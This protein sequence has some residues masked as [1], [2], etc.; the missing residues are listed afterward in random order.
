MDVRHI[1]AYKWTQRSILQLGLQVGGHLTDF[2]IWLCH[3]DSNI[4]VVL[5]VIIRTLTCCC[6][7]RKTIYGDT[8][9]LDTYFDGGGN[10]NFAVVACSVIAWY[11]WAVFYAPASGAVFLVSL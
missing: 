5:H 7:N 2:H 1:A 4:N 3:D 9:L 8:H 10:N 6:G 11:L